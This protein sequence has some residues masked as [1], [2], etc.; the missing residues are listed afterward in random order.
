MKINLPLVAVAVLGYLYLTRKTTVAGPPGSGLLPFT[1]GTSPITGL[2][3]GKVEPLSG[4]VMTG[5]PMLAQLGSLG[6][7]RTPAQAAQANSAR[8]RAQAIAQS[9]AGIGSVLRLW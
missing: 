5:N 1:P 7:D 8:L 4:A 9:N 3:G 6:D 2:T